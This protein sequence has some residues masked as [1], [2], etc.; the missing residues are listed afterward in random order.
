M[1]L[2]RAGQTAP[3]TGVDRSDAEAETTVYAVPNTPVVLLS[4]NG[5]K[6]SAEVKE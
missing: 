1:A 5:R 2:H 4:I 3:L 6:G